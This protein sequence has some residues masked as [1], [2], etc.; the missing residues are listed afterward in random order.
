MCGNLHLGTCGMAERSE[1]LV[2]YRQILFTEQTGESFEERVCPL[3]TPWL[4]TL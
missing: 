1:N 3:S 4:C 2:H